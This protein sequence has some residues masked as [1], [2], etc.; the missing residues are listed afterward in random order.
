MNLACF[1]F[2]L[3]M[4]KTEGIFFKKKE[5]L[6]HLFLK[7]MVNLLQTEFALLKKKC[8]AIRI[9]TNMYDIHESVSAMSDDVR[10]CF[11]SPH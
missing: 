10:I 4:S 7:K 11:G 1:F 2:G 9:H 8:L 6:G 3:K 5:S